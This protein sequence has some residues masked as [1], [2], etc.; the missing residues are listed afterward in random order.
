MPR[1]VF[2]DLEPTVVDEV[3]TGTYRQLFHPEQLNSGK[4]DATNHSHEAT[5]PSVKGSWIWCSTASG[6]WQTI[7]LAS[8]GSWYIMLAEAVRALGLLSPPGAPL[9]GLWQKVQVELH[10]VGMSAGGH[11][12]CG[13]IQPVRCIHS[14]LENTD[15]TVMYDN[16]GL[17]EALPGCLIR[18]HH[19]RHG[20]SF[21]FKA[22]KGAQKFFLIDAIDASRRV[23]K[24]LGLIIMREILCVH[25]DQAGVQIGNT[26]WEL[27]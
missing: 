21:P 15:I 3:R 7:A 26:C 18:C 22:I 9:R 23:S 14:L 20:R 5:T 17:Y 13:T 19:W 24:L 8:R 12:C 27:F 6:S 1:A 10:G 4:E 25:L 11:S 2:V 16:E